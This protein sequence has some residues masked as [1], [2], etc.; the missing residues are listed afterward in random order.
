MLRMLLY[1]FYNPRAYA[2]AIRLWRLRFVLYYALVSVLAAVFMSVSALE[3]V[4]KIY[5]VYVPSFVKIADGV[6]IDKGKVSPSGLE[7]RFVRNSL[8]E[9]VAALSG[10]PLTPEESKGLLFSIEGSSFV[11]NLY[12]T[13]SPVETSL[14]ELVPMSEYQPVPLVSLVPP[15]NLAKYFVLPL[16]LTAV[17][18]FETALYI[19]VMSIAAFI[20]SMVNFP[21]LGVFGSVK[22][23]TIAI[24]PAT[25]ING[26][27]T[28]V[29]GFPMPGFAFALVTCGVMIFV[30]SSWRRA[31]GI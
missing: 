14:A 29:M 4:G 31:R 18:L 23:A 17:S 19:A 8:G 20:M 9:P 6:S 27:V 1:S 5:S 2:V 22:F 10:R 25:L 11:A 16:G 21:R 13:S 15:E 26:F 12:D 7:P 30:F 24:T 3:N 28:C